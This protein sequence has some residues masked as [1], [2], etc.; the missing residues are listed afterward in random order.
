MLISGQILLPDPVRGV[1]L[2]PGQVR[3]DGPRIAAVQVSGPPLGTP[4]VGCENCLISPG[5][6]DTH[7]HLPQF[8]CLGIDGLTLLDWLDKAVFPTEAKWSDADHAGAAATR[9]AQRLLAAGTT[10]IAAYATV[11]HE[12]TKAAI[13]A[14]DQSGLRAIVGQVLM[15]QQAPAELIRPAAQLLKEAAALQGV[16][17]VET[18]ITPRFAVSCSH[19]LLEGCGQL[20]AKTS[21]PIQTHLSETTPECALVRKLHNCETYTE[22]YRRAGL[23]TKRTILGHGIW[24]S[25]AE[26]TM[27]RESASVIAHCPTANIFLQAGSMDRAGHLLANL[28]LS[29][30]SDIAGGPDVSMPRV[31]RAMIETAKSRALAWHRHPTPVPGSTAP[32]IPTP[33]KA[34]AQITWKN[35]DALG[36]PDAGRIQQGAPAD[37]VIINPT[38]GPAAQPNW[39]EAVDPLSLLLYT[40]DERWITHTILNGRIAYT[41]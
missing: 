24:L 15:D 33:A 32:P 22:V 3:L 37:L 14:I 12:G 25:P 2:T 17:R 16:G 29:L 9:A 27:I 1:R 8:D 36:W 34:W 26:Q 5:F 31:A 13:R 18:A 20:A 39:R 23:L 35:A 19:K 41:D 38:Q 7:L 21:A 10:G 11:H 30:G 40:F 4:D 28:R 6:I